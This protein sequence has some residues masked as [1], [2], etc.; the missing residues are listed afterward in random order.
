M[1][2]MCFVSRAEAKGPLKPERLKCQDPGK[3]GAETTKWRN[4]LLV[5]GFNPF[6]KY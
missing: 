1:A 5:G 4:V 3:S 6:E 2:H